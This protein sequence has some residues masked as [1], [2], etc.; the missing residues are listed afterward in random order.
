[1]VSGLSRTA[2]IHPLTR[3]FLREGVHHQRSRVTPF[4]N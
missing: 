3:A 2:T 4:V 1:M